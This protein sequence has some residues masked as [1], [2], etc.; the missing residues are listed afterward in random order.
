MPGARFFSGG[1]G[2]IVVIL[3]DGL[4]EREE[5][6]EAGFLLRAVPLGQTVRIFDRFF[7]M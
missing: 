7:Q 6:I 1:A 4:I 3:L 2:A 5:I